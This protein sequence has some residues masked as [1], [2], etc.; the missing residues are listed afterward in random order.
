[1][2]YLEFIRKIQSRS[3]VETNTFR[4]YRVFV[5]QG[6]EDFL[7]TKALQS[8]R[9][10]PIFGGISNP[11]I[12]GE[13]KI[14]LSD[15]FNE[16]ILLNEL[17]SVPFLQKENLVVLKLSSGRGVTE[18]ISAS[19][20]K[21]LTA[22]SLFSR[23]IIFADRWAP[24]SGTN[25]NRLIDNRGVIIDCYKISEYE[26]PQWVIAECTASGKLISSQNA[27]IVVERTGNDLG[28]LDA[29]IQNLV[30]FVGTRSEIELPDIDKFVTTD[31]LYE[32]KQL[33][34][35]ITQHQTA[36]AVKIIRQLLLKG[37]SINMIIGYL[38][39]YFKSESAPGLKL[40]LQK[41]LETDVAIKTGVMSEDLAAEMLVLKLAPLEINATTRKVGSA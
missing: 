15:D 23:L 41:L 18:E 35:A 12:T 19:L 17:Y 2:T 3:P 13:P 30:L 32:T 5:F 10:L 39:W 31:R 1:M 9:S 28:K 34:R 27:R 14:F 7:K 36:E 4:E 40:K 8:I 25:L 24:R 11:D 6:P 20:E 29:L 37:E 21:Y 22:P 16:S 33:G 26:I 38:A